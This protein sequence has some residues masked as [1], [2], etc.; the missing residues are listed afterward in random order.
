MPV[1]VVAAAVLA[2]AVSL[3]H[4]LKRSRYRIERRK[5]YGKLNKFNVLRI[6]IIL[7]NLYCRSIYLSALSLDQGLE[8]KKKRAY[9]RIAQKKV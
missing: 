5:Q 8:G 4:H 3:V 1:A 9:R 6:W 7:G 2:A